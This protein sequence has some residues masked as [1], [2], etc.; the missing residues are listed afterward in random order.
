VWDRVECHH[1][2]ARRI[3]PH[4]S[5]VSGMWHHAF[6]IVDSDDYFDNSE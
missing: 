6:I 3:P 4:A 1:D 2:E 5:T